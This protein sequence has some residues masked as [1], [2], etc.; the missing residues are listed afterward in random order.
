MRVNLRF[1]KI[2][3][4]FV[5]LSNIMA[6]ILLIDT[7][8]EVCLVALSENHAIKATRIDTNGQNH[9]KLIG[10]FVQE[11]L[12]EAACTAHQLDA[13]AL[14]AG[15]GSYTGLRIGTSFVKGLC[16]G[17]NVPVITL[18]T[19][20]ILAQEAL[21]QGIN[22]PTDAY[23]CPMIDARRMEVYTAVYGTQAQ[24]ITPAWPEI[25][26]ETSYTTYLNCPTYFFGN[27]AAKCQNTLTHPNAH[28]IPN[29]QPSATAM[30][31][32]A[33]KAYNNQAFADTAYFEPFY[34]KEFMATVPKN[35]LF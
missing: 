27:G 1:S 15:P 4:T 33:E 14:S 2:L 5:A 13:V 9:S 18:P 7:S 17:A 10:T 31:L 21:L 19:L 22:I 24:E 26:T 11:V 25:V 16:F 3:C 8:T 34:L 29:I 6:K 32:L 20:Q 12:K 35:K 30:M 28:F 23:L